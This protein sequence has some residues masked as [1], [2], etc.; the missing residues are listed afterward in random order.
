MGWQLL[1]IFFNVIAPVFA[2]VLIGYLAAPKLRLDPRTLSRAAYFLF[3]PAYVFNAVSGAEINAGLIGRMVAFALVVHLLIALIAYLTARLLR[4]SA[5]M[6]GA[7]VILAIFGNVGNFGLPLI[8]FRLGE[9]AVFPATIYFLAILFIAFTVSVAAAS[10]RQ[11]T[12]WRTAVEVFKTPALLALMP[13]VLNNGIDLQLPLMVTR[14]T[15]LLGGAMVPVMLLTLGAQLA[16]MKQ[17]RLSRDVWIAS[18]LRLVGAA[19]LAILLAPL[20]GLSGLARGAGIFQS[21]MPPAVL[22]S[23]I[24]IEYD[25][26]PDFVTTTVLVST[27]GS[28]LTLTLLF[29]FV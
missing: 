28:L 19:A 20:F 9:E 8:T 18:G 26:L 12:S 11:R 21:A 29:A 15:T 23:I 1:S 13:A 27:L 25:L 4:R 14:V 5:D 6:T 2:L 7:Y 17:I 22:A 24:A 3:V 10:R 16:G